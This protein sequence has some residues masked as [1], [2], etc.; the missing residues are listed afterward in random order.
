MATRLSFKLSGTSPATMRWARPSAI[1]VLPTPGSP[2]STG[3]FLVRRESTWSTRRI[4]W[5]RPMTGSSFPARASWVKSRVYFSS[6]SYCPSALGSVTRWVPRT[7]WR[8]VMTL[9]WVTPS[10]LSKRVA[11]SLDRDKMP[12]RICSVLR[13]SSD[14]PWAAFQPASKVV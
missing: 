12:S 6:A 2:M 4:S 5:S 10:S 9:S 11:S 13:Y 3:L 8:A 1:A 14:R 7:L